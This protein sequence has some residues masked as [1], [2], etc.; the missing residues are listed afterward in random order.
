MTKAS[1]A[2]IYISVL[3]MYLCVCL[4]ICAIVHDCTFVSC[5]LFTVFPSSSVVNCCTLGFG[6]E[7]RNASQ[8]PVDSGPAYCS[9]DSGDVR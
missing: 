6:A 7:T 8:C 5:R 9:D 4:V 1:S 3:A 2:Y